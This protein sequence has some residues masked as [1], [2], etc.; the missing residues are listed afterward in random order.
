VLNVGLV[1]LHAQEDEANRSR[2]TPLPAQGSSS[3]L[4]RCALAAEREGRR[5]DARPALP[6]VGHGSFRTILAVGVLVGRSHS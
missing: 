4:L 1:F 5:R 2:T 6:P 3:L